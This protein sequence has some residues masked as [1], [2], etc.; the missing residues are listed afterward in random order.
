MKY[1]VE[2]TET[3]QKQIEVE[4]SSSDEAYAKVRD[5]YKQGKIV[6]DETSYIDT[7]FDVKKKRRMRN[8]M[9]R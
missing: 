2:I 8:E 6:L 5:D 3:L 1:I 9:E 7:D 4:A